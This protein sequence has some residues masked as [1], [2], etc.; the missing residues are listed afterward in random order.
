[1]EK[2]IGESLEQRTAILGNISDLGPP[3]M[4]HLAKMVSNSSTK[5]PTTGTFFYYTGTDVSNSATIAALLHSIADII[6]EKPQLWFGKHKSWKVCE[7]TY[8]TYDAFSEIDARV[9]V[10]FPGGVELRVLD[11]EGNEIASTDRLWLEIYVCAIVRALITADNDSSDFSSVVEIRKVNPLL[12]KDQTKLFF[13]GFEKLFFEGTK[14]GCS[15]KLQVATNGNNNLVDAFLACVGLT[16]EFD[17][18]IAIIQ[19]LRSIDPSIGFLEAKINLMADEEV[20]AVKIMHDI[21]DANPLDG[22]ALSLQAEFCIEKK[23]LDLA[24]PLATKAMNS[25]PWY[26]KPWSLLVKTYIRTGKYEKALLTL[27]S[28]PMVTHKDKYILKRINNPKPEDMHLPLPV[29]V[30]LDKVSTLNS[31]DVA[32]EHN[33]VDPTL[34]GLP[35]ASLKS[36]FAEAYNLLTEIVHK[37]GWEMLLKYRTHVFV[38]EGE[39]KGAKGEEKTDKQDGVE[40]IK[41]I[42]KLNSSTE[43][44]KRK[45]LPETPESPQSEKSEKSGKSDYKNKQLCERWLD[46]LFM[47]LYDDLRVYTM[48]K[49]E[50]MHFEAQKVEMKK[51]TLEW[52]LTGLVAQRLGHKEEAASCF[53]RG[54]DTRFSP[55]C[56]SQLLKYYLEHHSSVEHASKNEPVN[57]FHDKILELTVNLLV[58]NHRW[59]CGFSPELILSLKD[60]VNEV[61]RVK[62]ESEVKVQFDDKNTGIYDLVLDNL[63]FL[64]TYGLIE[65][66]E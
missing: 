18:A 21:V 34:M 10:N 53:K 64:D 9:K 13:E 7:A 19:R 33:R 31:V 65:K 47:L 30:T 51:T 54:L 40:G 37:T 61:G 52:E 11:S 29:D 62:I 39:F 3:D 4:V 49:A 63:S 45:A 23:R 5:K 55:R 32:I 42:D 38:M 14:L 43:N 35:A 60:L 1:M 27:N 44:Y 24:L 17:E 2:T 48:Y 16:G 8:C 50:K 41:K 6:D 20:R 66:E 56:T 28:C 12:T 25:A 46:N 22:E 57:D 58:W 15:E 36:T 26:F 59:Y